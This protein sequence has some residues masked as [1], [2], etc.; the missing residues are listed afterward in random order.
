MLLTLAPIPQHWEV[1]QIVPL[2]EHSLW[3]GHSDKFFAGII[4]LRLHNNT[5]KIG[6]TQLLY[7][8]LRK[9]SFGTF[10]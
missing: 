1:L 9:L 2:M 6:T 4:S 5:Y 3:E 10:K 7:Y 8:K